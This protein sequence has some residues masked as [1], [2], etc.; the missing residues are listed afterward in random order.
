M[1][2]DLLSID[3]IKQGDTFQLNGIFKIDGVATSLDLYTIKSQVR[4]SRDNLIAELS[5]TKDPSNTGYFSLSAGEIDWKPATY[6]CDIEFVDD[7]D[8][9]RSSETFL[10]PVVKEITHV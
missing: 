7:D 9:V 1:T 5:V 4:D 3:P 8:F 6:Y 10:I 2:C